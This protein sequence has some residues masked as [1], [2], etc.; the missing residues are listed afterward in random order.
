MDDARAALNVIVAREVERFVTL[1]ASFLYR[2]GLAQHT[3]LARPKCQEIVAK[4]R[5]LAW[6]A[7]VRAS[8]AQTGGAGLRLPQALMAS[9]SSTCSLV[10]AVLLAGLVASGD[11]NAEPTHRQEAL[12]LARRL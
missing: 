11:F 6:N 8:F 3:L 1:L 2:G 10:G 12:R 5:W 7:S 9:T 4:L